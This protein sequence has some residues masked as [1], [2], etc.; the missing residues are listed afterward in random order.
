MPA[1]RTERDSILALVR[2]RIVSYA[3][4]RIGREDAEDLAQETLLLLNGKY[5]HLESPTDLVPLAVTIM[6]FKMREL[7]NRDRDGNHES[8]DRNQVQNGG[9][10]PDSAAGYE[11]LRERILRAAEKLGPRCQEIFLLKLEG[12]NFLEIKGRMGAGSIN[13]IYTWDLRCRKE[14]RKAMGYAD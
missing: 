11:Q 13:T 3:A 2:E 7:R 8:L 4:S 12:Y 1:S 9:L 6:K 10:G 5:G 14:L